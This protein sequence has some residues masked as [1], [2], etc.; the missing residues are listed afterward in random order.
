MKNHNTAQYDNPWGN[1][2]RA[3][4]IA[5]LGGFKI[6]PIYIYQNAADTLNKFYPE[7]LRS[8]YLSESGQIWIELANTNRNP[9]SDKPIILGISPFEIQAAEAAKANNKP[10]GKENKLACESM[11]RNFS[12][13]TGADQL[14]IENI[15]QIASVIAQLDGCEKIK[16]EHVAEAM[17][18]SKSIFI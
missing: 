1:F 12:N 2:N 6:T 4:Q 5:I 8:A 9:Y 17:H 16:T 18:Y 3:L 14:E 13:R 10:D 15:Y 7:D 11:I